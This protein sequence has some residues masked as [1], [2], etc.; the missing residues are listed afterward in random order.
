MECKMKAKAVLEVVVVFSLTLF[1][2]ALAGLSPVGEWVRQVSKRTFFEYVVMIAVPLLLLVVTRRDLASCG[3]SLRNLRY[4][5]DI[6]AAAFVPIAVGIA[7]AGLVNY[8][9]WW[10][11]LIMAG[12]QIAL[13]FALGRLLKRKPTRNESGTLVT[14]SLV[15]AYSNLTQGA[16]LNSAISAL[17]F[18]VFFLGLGEELLFRGYIQSR[19]NDAF[20]RPFQFYGV[21][22]GWGIVITSVLF[23][24]MHVINLG[25]LAIGDWQLTPWWGL[26]T[27]FAGLVNGFVREKTGSIVAPTIL[28]GLPQGIAY[29]VLGR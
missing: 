15:I 3:I 7:G 27:F 22:W 17:L 4:H 8:T 14:A 2:V 23:G 16:T 20:G 26:W 24:L 28:H 5:L 6:T 25:S 12:V 13:L 1:L 18:Y 11:A 9:L 21:K 10:G 29:A 19:L